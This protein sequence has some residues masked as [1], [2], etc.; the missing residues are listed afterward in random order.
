[1]TELNLTTNKIDKFLEDFISRNKSFENNFSE[2]LNKL[3]IEV[4]NVFP[5]TSSNKS[6]SGFVLIY[7][8]LR[9]SVSNVISSLR[10]FSENDNMP[11][12]SLNV[13][14]IETRL[15]FI[16]AH[17][18]R[19]LELLNLGMANKSEVE[20]LIFS[21]IKTL[22]EFI[23][24][25]NKALTEVSLEANN[26]SMRSI[27][28]SANKSLEMCNILSSDLV[29]TFDNSIINDTISERLGLKL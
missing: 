5:E 9:L 26:A 20:V 17:V 16:K 6:L 27:A 19:V 18:A 8:S 28:E 21:G 4:G 14:E 2:T 7:F 10:S 23:P 15:Q 3:K 1:M 12:S 29:K 11:Y 24:E 13:V 25:V 22:S